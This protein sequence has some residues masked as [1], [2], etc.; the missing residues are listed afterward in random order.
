[1][2]ALRREKTIC[3]VMQK[4]HYYQSLVA[5][6]GW[7]PVRKVAAV[8]Q[9]VKEAV[10]GKGAP[11][12]MV[13]VNPIATLREPGIPPTSFPLNKF[14]GTF[15][16]IVDTYG[17]PR[18]KEVNP[19]LFTIIT[20]PFLFGVMYGDIGHGIIITL[21]A[22]GLIMAENFF[23][24]QRAR[25]QIN[26]IIDMVFEGRYMLLLMGLFAIYAGTIYNDVFS[27][28]TSLFSSGYRLI[29]G[30]KQTDYYDLNDRPYP[31]GLDPAWPNHPNELAFHNSFKMKL[32]VILGVSQMAFGITLSLANHIYFR[33]YVSA[34]FEFIPRMIFLLALCQTRERV[35]TCMRASATL[36]IRC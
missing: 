15:Q 16:N 19:G 36:M 14:T 35:Q 23:Y 26:E 29:H 13:E 30:K 25:K 21:V 7:V 5:L 31:F 34:W 10:L 20:F 32:S 18:Y 9:A 8:Q 28:A 24:R 2:E 27:I 22:F 12:A 33:D 6:E 17:V 4:A 3:A 11:P 1:M